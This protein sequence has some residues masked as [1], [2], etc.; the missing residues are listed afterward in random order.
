MT[1]TVARRL[2]PVYCVIEHLH[3]DLDVARH[4]CEGR[5]RIAGAQ[6]CVGPVPDWRAVDLDRDVERWIEW[7]KFY[8]GLDMACAFARTG[9]PTFLRTWERFVTSWVAQVPADFGP[10][11]ALGRRLQNWI[12]AANIFAAAPTFSGFAGGFDD[13]LARQIAEHADY[14]QAHLTPERNHR[15]LELYALF[16]AALA[17]PA[18]DREAERLS[19][20]WRA[21]QENLLSDFRPD[22]VHRE[23]STHYHM[24][25][26]RSFIGARENAR[27]AG[28]DIPAAYD[29]ALRRAIDFAMYCH[30]P[31]GTMP[32]LSDGDIG[33]YGEVLEMAAHAL[34]RPDVL[35][36]ETG[37]RAGMAPEFSCADF[38]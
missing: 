37:G 38:P 1:S 19:V 2:R 10:T 25:V 4:A 18:S 11:D 35:F 16:I 3:R 23:H 20:A 22:G 33:G 34:E 36:V 27:R 7:S 24:I 28:L 30:R 14:L 5:F 9:D 13:L 15:T 8:Y 31:D 26:L 17:L 12:Y 29:A 6:L 21:L 32:A